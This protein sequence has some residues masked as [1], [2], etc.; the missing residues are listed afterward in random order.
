MSRLLLSLA[1]ALA[2]CA[3]SVPP[4]VQVQVQVQAAQVAVAA[5]DTVEQVQAA[6]ADPVEDAQH[7]IAA[8]LVPAVV[9][10]QDVM[11]DVLPAPSAPA[12][13]AAAAPE[14]SP[15][16]VALIVGFEIISPAYY[17]RR[18]QSPVWPGGASGATIGI[19][20]D[21]GHASRQG[22]LDDWASHPQLQRL[23]P[24][25]GVMGAPARQLVRSMRDV[26]TPLADAQRV[27]AAATLPTYDALTAR[28]YANGWDALLPNARGSL[29]ATVYNRGASMRGDRRREMREL[30]DTCVPTGDTACMAAQYRAMCRLWAGTDTGVGLCRRYEATARL[31]E[32]RA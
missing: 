3:C 18:L 20:Y 29:T 9:A 27:F 28:A 17:T 1:A 7:G 30:R 14:V 32:L 5:T 4:A 15:A 16:A 24:A 26:R 21:L 6:I 25:A 10:V 13:A 22:I 2:L 23:L 8:A 12:L 11:V 31:A 19:G